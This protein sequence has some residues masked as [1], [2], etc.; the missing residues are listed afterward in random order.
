MLL[1]LD[2]TTCSGTVLHGGIFKASQAETVVIFVTGVEGNIHN[3][4]FYTVIGQC[5]NARNIDMIVAH[6]RDAFN[7][8]TRVNRLSGRR[9]TY[10]SFNEHFGDSDEDIEAYLTFVKK[11]AYQHIVLGWQS[12]G[13][14]KVIHYL[15]GHSDASIDKFL[16]MSPVNLA[17][18]RSKISK[19]Q[20]L[21]IADLVSRGAGQQLL[22][23]RLFRWLS[24]TAETGNQW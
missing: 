4:P 8:V 2:V 7:R 24:C 16:L 18:L 13:A 19:L 10:G 15:A 17:I 12:L 20:R 1:P 6:T 21:T 14:N 22:P 5:L 11:E 3:N 9:K 23:F